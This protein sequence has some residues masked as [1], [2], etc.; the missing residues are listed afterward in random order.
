M[1]GQLGKGVEG[2]LGHHQRD[3][4]DRLQPFAQQ[5][6]ALVVAGCHGRNAVAGSPQSGQGTAL[7]EAADIAGALAL[8]GGSGLDHRGGSGQIPQPPTRH[9][10]SLG[11]AVDREAALAQI[12]G[13]CSEAVV[14]LTLGQKIF[15]DLIAHHQHPG[16]TTEQLSQGLQLS[17]AG[18]PPGGIPR[19]VEHQQPGSGRDGVFQLGD[20]QPKTTGC[21]RGNDHACGPRKGRHLGVAKPVGGWDQHLI[22]GVEQHLEQ[23][24]DRLLAAIGDHHLIGAR[25]TAVFPRQLFG[26]GLPQLRVTGSRAVTGDAVGEGLPCRLRDELGGVE[27]GFAST[28][29][30]DVATIVLQS[31]GLGT[32]LKCQRRLQGNSPLGE[33]R[34]ALHGQRTN[35]QRVQSCI[36]PH[37]VSPTTPTRL[38]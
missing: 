31:L 9:G 24:V 7:G 25:W 5:R 11:E 6:P 21:T 4:I 20:I 32:D 26:D 29:T 36:L 2:A 30:A 34:R 15:I 1:V 33:F 3:A 13:H 19:S 37:P 22:T 28:E 12:V 10:P 17:E 16:M 14:N 18:D 23:V 35:P 38:N 8:Q 27:V